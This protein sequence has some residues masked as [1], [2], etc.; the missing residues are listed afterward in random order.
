MTF[1]VSF[2]GFVFFKSKNDAIN[3]IPLQSH[4]KNTS[5]DVLPFSFFIFVASIVIKIRKRVF[6][7]YQF[8]PGFVLCNFWRFRDLSARSD[9]KLNSTQADALG[10]FV[11]TLTFMPWPYNAKNFFFCPV[12]VFVLLNRT[13]YHIRYRMMYIINGYYI[14]STIVRARRACMHA[15]VIFITLYNNV[16]RSDIISIRGSNCSNL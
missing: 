5:A 16:L 8:F 10:F 1:F 11:F 9:S 13:V 12:K 7:W 2:P 4:F 6:S 14:R 3:Y 15:D